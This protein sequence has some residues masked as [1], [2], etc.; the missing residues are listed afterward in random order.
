MFHLKN[1]KLISQTFELLT[2]I[3]EKMIHT[4]RIKINFS[5]ILVGM[6]NFN[7]SILL[8]NNNK[9]MNANNIDT[10]RNT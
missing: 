3:N 10:K 2:L 8:I 9:I 5:S 6:W 1:K 4:L 7:Q